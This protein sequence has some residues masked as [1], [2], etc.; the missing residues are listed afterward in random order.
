MAKLQKTG[1]QLIAFAGGIL[2]LFLTVYSWRYTMQISVY[3]EVLTDSADSF[4]G[5]VLLLLLAA[6]IVFRLGTW[7]KYL[8]A[9][10]IHWLSV[11]AAFV[12]VL[13]G[14]KLVAD[15]HGVTECD[16][17]H[18]YM[19][20]EDICVYGDRF[21]SGDDYFY[22]FPNQLGLAGI[23]AVLLQTAGRCSEDVLRVVHAL[24]AGIIVYMGFRIVRELSDDRRAEILYLCGMVSYLPLYLYIL[25][26]YGE[27]LGLCAAFCAVWFF[28]R[29]NRCETEKKW[30]YWIAVG[31][32]MTITYM[33]RQGLLVVGIA[34]LIVQFFQCLRERRVIPLLCMTGILIM[35]MGIQSLGI[36]VSQKRMG[37]DFGDGIPVLSWIAMGMQE[38]ET[39]GLAPGS[40][41]GYLV[42]TYREAGYDAQ[43]AADMSRQY[44][45]ERLENWSQ[46]PR[47]MLLFY[48]MKILSQWNEP[49]YGSFIMTGLMDDP[50]AW[51]EDLYHGDS[52]MRW[53]DWLNA[54]QGVIYLMVLG[55]F[56][57]LLP[58]RE[59]P[60]QYL[61]GLI[62]IG[63]F[64]FSVLWEAK[65][66]YIYPYS[67]LAIPF[68]AMSLV[69]YY[70]KLPGILRN[71]RSKIRSKYKQ[72]K[73]R[74]ECSD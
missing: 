41:N 9:Q 52:R 32:S 73:R 18:L 1:V 66:R 20:S 46:S 56:L 55:G 10:R 61:P 51:V 15:A 16:Q 2:F 3:S 74:S 71:C 7:K 19:A 37:A 29:A 59:A 47:D 22:C 64:C 11:C 31:I 44:I 26:V 57:R 48:K 25:F 53:C 17:L 34:M 6:E 49:T 68:A 14:L 27:T 28:L 5:K 4:I 38:N 69:Y 63:G 39:S 33:A 40:Y 65:G 30:F 50:Q 43:A 58:G 12:T 60:E 23:Y 13:I 21:V 67:V 24:C 36:A 72:E 35:A 42:D 54:F 45:A 8:T 62:L 70:D